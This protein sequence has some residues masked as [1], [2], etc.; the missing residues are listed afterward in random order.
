VALDL[1]DFAATSAASAIGTIAAGAI[2]L[3]YAI[4]KYRKE[5]SYERRLEW[6]E[7]AIR[8]L[9]ETANALI[10]ALNSTRK[11]ELRANQDSNWATVGERFGKLLPLETEAELYA[12][13]AAYQAIRQIT[14]DVRMLSTAAEHVSRI[15]A[16]ATTSK[17]DPLAV[18]DIIVRLLLHGASRLATD[19]RKELDLE[20]LKRENRLYD[21]EFVEHLADLQRRGLMPKPEDA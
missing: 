15:Q 14:E 20:T 2:G 8:D 21:D 12:S 5:R 16:T 9:V 11:P 13:N 3:R 18:Y 1:S 19:V 10:R 4:A 7:R 6:H 17:A